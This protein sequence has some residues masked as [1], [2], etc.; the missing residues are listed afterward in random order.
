MEMI[1]NGNDLSNIL[2]VEEVRRPF[3]SVESALAVVPGRTGKVFRVQNRQEKKIEVDIRLI[4]TRREEITEKAHTLRSLL[5]ASEP[6]K[7][8]LRDEPT[9]YDLAILDGEIPLE[10]FCATGFVTLPFLCPSGASYSA[11]ETTGTTNGGTE[12]TPWTLSG[13]ASGG[14]IKISAPKIGRAVTID[15]DGIV[16]GDQIKIDAEE[17]L[18][19]VNGA[20]AM[21]RLFYDSVFWELSP[22]KNEITVTGLSSYSIK[23][24]GRWL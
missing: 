15:G 16:S 14:Q 11:E 6:Q 4:A 13:T 23:H 10:R 7:L 12:S 8:V 19:W 9:R 17:E 2:T 18:I 1:Y 3:L 20:L 5:A 21:Q 24:R 22:G